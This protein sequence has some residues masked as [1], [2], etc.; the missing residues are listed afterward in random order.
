[1]NNFS[2]IA[3][4][5]NSL[6]TTKAMFKVFNNDSEWELFQNVI[7]VKRISYAKS[8]KEKELFEKIKS[9]NWIDNTGTRPDFISDDLMIEMFEIDD[10]VTTKKGKNNPQ[11][12]ADARAM[13]DAKKFIDEVGGFREDIKIIANGDTRYNPETDDYNKEDSEEH[14]NYLAYIENFQRICQKHLNS[15]KAYRENYPSKKLG[16][17]IVD[18]ATLYLPRL[19]M[20]ARDVF[21]SLPFYDKNFMKLFVESDVDFVIWAFDNK[22]LY[23]QDDSRGQNSFLPDVVIIS[24][25]NFYNKHS[26]KFDISAMKSLEE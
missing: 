8:K 14:H 3:D 19:K 15:T 26:K 12:K 20:K 6:G 9:S 1:M 17:L 10:I 16:F 23:T 5:L 24:K 25:D 11:R 7:K 4:A 22:Y 2:E 18:G 13:R 21:R